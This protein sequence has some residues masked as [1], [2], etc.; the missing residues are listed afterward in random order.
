VIVGEEGVWVVEQQ[1]IYHGW[2]DNIALLHIVS[3]CKIE[4]GWWAWR[5]ALTSRAHS[6]RQDVFSAQEV[7]QFSTPIAHFSHII[8]FG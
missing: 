7:P 2:V 1:R 4:F 5:R 3:F 8:N 6:P